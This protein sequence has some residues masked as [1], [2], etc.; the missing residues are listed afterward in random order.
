M[1]G[2]LDMQGAQPQQPMMG[3]LLGAAPQVGGQMPSQDEKMQALRLTNALM[4]NP[5]PQTVKMIISEISKTPSQ[6]G[7][8]IIG[9]LNQNLNNPEKLVQFAQDVANSLK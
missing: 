5:T 2:L 6:E 9:I 1:N 4:Q 7:Q 3:G 8:T